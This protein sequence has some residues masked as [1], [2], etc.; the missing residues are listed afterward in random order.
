M[1]VACR[2]SHAMVC[3]LITISTN[4]E[5]ESAEMAEKRCVKSARS[6]GYPTQRYRLNQFNQFV[7]LRAWIWGYGIT[8]LFICAE[9][10]G[11]PNGSELV[12]MADRRWACVRAQNLRWL[13]R[14]EMATKGRKHYEAYA[15]EGTELAWHRN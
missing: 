9:L 14:L 6:I 13:R 8:G 7:L 15:S 12:E 4:S 1:S 11:V 2:S 10:R 3:H 5:S